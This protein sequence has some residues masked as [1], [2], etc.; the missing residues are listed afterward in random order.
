[1]TAQSRQEKIIAATALI[2]TPEKANSFGTI[3]QFLQA[4]QK[5]EHAILDIPG[6]LKMSPDARQYIIDC[7]S[8]SVT[9][10]VKTRLSQIFQGKK[11]TEIPT[12]TLN[13]FHMLVNMNTAKKIGVQI[14]VSL[15]VM[16]DKIVR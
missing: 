3:L 11:P 1:M 8:D 5:E 14:P 13:Y 16:A 9:R 2:L 12:S 4:V 10:D 6:V 15:M 7:K